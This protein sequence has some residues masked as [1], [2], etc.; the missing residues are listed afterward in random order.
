[1]PRR[2]VCILILWWTVVSGGNL[3]AGE[4]FADGA[5][6]G[7][8]P[9][10]TYSSPTIQDEDEPAETVRPQSSGKRTLYVGTGAFFAW[11]KIL[12]FAVVYFLWVMLADR[13]N[14]DLLKWGEQLK[15]PPQIWNLINVL[16]F[17]VGL[18]C[19]LAIPIFW[20]GWPFFLAAVVG[21]AFV[22]RQ[23]RSSRLKASDSLAFQVNPE[24]ADQVEVL[25]QDQGL[26]IDFTPAGDDKDA[27]Q[28]ALIQARRSP[29][30]PIVKNLVGNMLIK[31]A[32]LL[33]LDYTA[34]EVNGR[35]QVDGA[36]H[37]LPPLS[38]EEG[39]NTLVSFKFLAGLNPAERRVRQQG[40]FRCKFPAM[41]LKTGIEVLSQGV[42]TGERVQIKILRAT[43]KDLSLV[44]LGMW[45][46]SSAKLLE[47]LNN[48]GLSI[49][50]APMRNGLTTSW[51]SSLVT[52]DRYTRDCIVVID[53]TDA[54][55]EVENLQVKRFAENGS[56]MEVVRSAL[57]AQPE[58][59]VIPNIVNAETMDRLTEEVLN[60]D[61]TVV[62]RIHATTAAEAILRVFS[63]AKNKKQ[64]V[65]AFKVAT[66]QR[67][68]RKLC[69]NCKQPVPV[70]PDFVQKLGGDPQQIQAIYTHF[71]P[72][73]PGTV[74]EKGQPIEI[75][76]CPKCQ[77]FGYLGRTAIFE[78]VANN[79][80]L[81]S[82][83]L[84]K[85]EVATLA[86]IAKK[87]GNRDQMQEAYRLVLA[88]V[89]SIDE[90]KRVFQSK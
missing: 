55:S 16:S 84:G 11:Y 70:R 65:L 30:F 81:T 17:L 12:L 68:V 71:T 49:I 19:V 8:G 44:E 38:R 14:R 18:V 7:V 58:V 29:A 4:S 27:R 85:P 54:E 28:K 40:I 87:T 43:G 2:A 51:R 56:P 76:V 63:L 57:L 86:A 61:R 41:D 35:M 50:S 74:D 25:V 22:Y 34:T 64:F 1:M 3:L 24:T 52:M 31:R 78:V 32:D 75:P 21:P 80:Q 89:T 48:P 20:V 79:E 88:G 60:Q 36:W 13:I 90:I 39:D 69:D 42:P 77:G 23:I 10:S 15:M 82:A 46:E 83:L 45:P 53:P 73:P 9:E 67:L 47:G 62:T 5:F 37:P 66:C 26:E 59:I 72:P 6:P 33:L